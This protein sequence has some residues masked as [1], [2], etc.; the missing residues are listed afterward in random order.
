[1]KGEWTRSSPEREPAGKIEF[2]KQKAPLRS[3][4]LWRLR[5]S[6]ISSIKRLHEEVGP[7]ACNKS[8][9]KRKNLKQK[10]TGSWRFDQPGRKKEIFRCE[11]QYEEP[12]KKQG[13]PLRRVISCYRFLRGYRRHGSPWWTPAFAGVTT[14]RSSLRRVCNDYFGWFPP[15][16]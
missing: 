15:F 5:A 3:A 8:S 14:G 6:E 2:V 1:V 16:L 13:H 10:A 11:E 7:P 9:K 12:R 4:G